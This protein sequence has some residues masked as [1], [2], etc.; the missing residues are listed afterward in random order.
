MLSLKY[1]VNDI[2]DVITVIVLFLTTIVTY[3]YDSLD[4]TATDFRIYVLLLI[5]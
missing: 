3:K 1:V 5:S 2:G 4:I